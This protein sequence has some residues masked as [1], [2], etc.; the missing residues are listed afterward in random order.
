[1]SALDKLRAMLAENH[2][3]SLPTA[4]AL[5]PEAPFHQEKKRL[6]TLLA[7]HG[8]ETGTARPLDDN[9]TVR[10]VESFA[11]TRRVRWFMDARVLCT[12]LTQ[13]IG[14][15]KIILI[16]VQALYEALMEQVMAFIKK[17]SLFRRLYRYA[18]TRFLFH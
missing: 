16:E 14:P 13:P 1:M 5:A 15:R 4:H 6:G 7:K 18:Y 17:P 2:R 3:N 8:K 11:E 10:T 9:R 12:A